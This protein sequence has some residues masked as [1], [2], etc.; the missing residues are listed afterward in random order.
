MPK[1]RESLALVSFLAYCIVTMIMTTSCNVQNNLPLAQENTITAKKNG[2]FTDAHK[3]QIKEV[4]ALINIYMKNVIGRIKNPKDNTINISEISHFVN[5]ELAKQNKP[6]VKFLQGQ[7]VEKEKGGAS[8]T[9]S[10]SVSAFYD[11]PGY[12]KKFA[13]GYDMNDHSLFNY[14]FAPVSWTADYWLHALS[15]GWKVQSVQVGT[16][17]INFAITYNANSSI[18]ANCFQMIAFALATNGQLYVGLSEYVWHGVPEW[19]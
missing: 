11:G 6:L 5:S 17:P 10:I 15:L 3:Q 19:W 18:Q 12:K 14:G 8:L 7:P 16:A 2:E 1:I 4:H 9:S 13:A